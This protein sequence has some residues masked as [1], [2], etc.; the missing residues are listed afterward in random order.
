MR[1]YGTIWLDQVVDK[2]ESKHRVAPAEVEE[3]F[4]NKP[5]YRKAE[6]GHYRGEDLYYAYGRT[7]A[8]R[9]LFVVFI[10]KRSQEALVVTSRDMDAKERRRHG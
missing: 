4:Y 9:Y 6:K 7:D 8:G 5:A 10:Y 2:I 1:I 3:V